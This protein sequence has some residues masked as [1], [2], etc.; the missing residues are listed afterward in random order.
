[1]ENTVEIERPDTVSGLKAKRKDLVKLLGKITAE[2]EK[3]RSSIKHILAE[4]VSIQIPADL[5]LCFTNFPRMKP[6]N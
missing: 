6:A 2:T 3:V 5:R 1:M 4:C